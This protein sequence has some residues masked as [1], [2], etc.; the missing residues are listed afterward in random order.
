MKKL[1]TAILAALVVSTAAAPSAMACYGVR[2][3]GMG[4][5]FIAVADDVQAVYWN[6]AGLAHIQEKQFGWQR[7]TNQ[8]GTTNYIDIYEFA[9]PLE[10]GKSGIGLHYTNDWDAPSF[11]GY[12]N[13]RSQ[14]WTLSY[15]Q[16]VSDKL[17]LGVNVRMEKQ[18]ADLYTDP[19]TKKETTGAPQTTYST[20]VGVLYKA[21]PK[22]TFGLYIQDSSGRGK[23][24]NWRPAVA[25]RPDNKTIIAFDI[26]N[27]TEAYSDKREHSIG[28]EHKVTDKIA[29]RAG[30]YHRSMTYGIGVKV[31]KDMELNF[32]YM[33]DDFNGQK[34][35][36]MQTKF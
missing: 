22:L 11:N 27:A 14:W 2:A 19:D 18:S 8:R 15:G 10:K 29:L 32:A 31:T 17:S 24:A 3:M 4:G 35:I 1:T 9:M 20:D 30:N 6:P 13:Y 33:G 26:Y 23:E 21:S 12:T 36:G 34:L 5:A 7:A 16:K 28:I 25:Y